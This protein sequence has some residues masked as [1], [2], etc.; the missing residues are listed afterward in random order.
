MPPLTSHGTVALNRCKRWGGDKAGNDL[1]NYSSSPH[2]DVWGERPGTPGGMSLLLT[3]LRGSS[4]SL[5]QHSFRLP[6]QCLSHPLMEPTWPGCVRQIWGKR[7]TLFPE[8]LE[9]SGTENIQMPF[10]VKQQ[11]S[12][13]PN[14]MTWVK[15]NP[16]H[17][18]NGTTQ[19]AGKPWSERLAHTLTCM[20]THTQCVSPWVWQGIHKPHTHKI[21]QKSVVFWTGELLL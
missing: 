15:Y 6:A 9:F 7:L 10:L 16:E 12:N 5:L 17:E 4:S 3:S 2:G 1:A 11:A 13:P 18:N 14:I 21:T 8:P 20:H 19:R